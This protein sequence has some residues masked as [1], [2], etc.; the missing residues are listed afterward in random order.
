VGPVAS[1]TVATVVAAIATYLGNRYGSGPTGSSSGELRPPPGPWT[2]WARIARR[3]HPKASRPRGGSRS[4]AAAPLPRQR[5]GPGGPSTGAG[6]GLP[7]APGCPRRLA[8]SASAPAAVRG[9]RSGRA[10]S[11]GPGPPAVLRFGHGEGQHARPANWRGS[12]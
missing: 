2:L 9:R 6:R 3:R 11:S 12:V 10:L 1:I 8:P 4:V 5:A 7:P